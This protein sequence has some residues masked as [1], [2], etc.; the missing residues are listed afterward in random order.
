MD[1]LLYYAITIDNTILPALS[2]ISAGQSIATA[3]TTKIVT[4]LL[5]Y[6]ATNPDV[7]I[8]YHSSD[9]VL[10]V[11]RDTSYLSVIKGRSRSSGIFS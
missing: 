1:T 8:Q 7:T 4:K 10:Y 3:T 2:E 6:L 5:N 11:H 9:M